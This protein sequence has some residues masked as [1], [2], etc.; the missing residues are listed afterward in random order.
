[1]CNSPLSAISAPNYSPSA[2]NNEYIDYPLQ[3]ANRSHIDKLTSQV[4]SFSPVMSYKPTEA[5]RKAK[6]RF[7]LLISNEDLAVAIAWTCMNIIKVIL[8]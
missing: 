5:V 8:V 7:R 2:P 1:M 4:A 3:I 6:E